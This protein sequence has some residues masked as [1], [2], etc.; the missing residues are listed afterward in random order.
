MVVTLT[1]NPSIDTGASVDQVQPERKLRCGKPDFE[2]GGGGLN[3]AR[4]L[5]RLGASATACYPCG[6]SNGDLL[7]SL[8]ADSDIDPR[9]VSIEGMT[10]EN[11]TISENNSDRQFRFVMPGPQLSQPEWDACLQV[12]RD[13]TDATYIVAS[14]S[15]PPGVPD[16][17]YARVA[18]IGRHNGARVI[19]DTSGEPLRLAVEEGV[20]LVKPNL[21]ELGDISGR[22]TDTDRDI[23][24]AAGELCSRDKCEAMVVSLGSGG[25]LLVNGDEIVQYRSPTV[26]IRSKV[27]AGDSMV[28]GII[29]GLTRD[30]PLDRAVRL[31]IAAGAA[32]VMTP[33]TELC[34]RK[35]TERLFAEL[36]EETHE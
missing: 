17:F 16:D 20:Y 8:L 29:A 31:G 9:P 30:W 12:I 3:V 5:V 1:M 32:A 14:G 6:G 18:S 7:N 11:V 22:P 35:D 27:G 10:R 2:P 36:E 25:A 19:V 24:Q 33:G 28:G 21:R 4:V 26:P 34:R 13:L 15:L 23:H